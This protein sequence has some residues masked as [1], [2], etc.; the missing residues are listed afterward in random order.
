MQG[1]LVLVTGGAGYIGSHLVRKLLRRGHRVRVLDSLLYGDR[2]LVQFRGNPNFE[3]LVGDVRSSGDLARA[4]KDARAVVAL[5]ALV[6]D[7]A[8]AIDPAATWDINVDA[9][10][11]LLARCGRD[12]VERLVFASSCSVYGANGAE[13]LTEHSHLNPVSLYARTRI[14]SEELLFR[15]RGPVDV[16]VLRLATVC[17]LSERMRFDLMV[18][19]LTANA[20]IHGRIRIFG[21]QQ[22]R[23]HI[24]VQD[25]ADAF[26]RAVEAPRERAANEIFNVG[27]E[28]QN[29]TVGEVADMVVEHIP[30]TTQEQQNGVDDQRSY[31]VGFAHI[32]EKLGFVP[33]RTVDDA[34]SEVHA[35]LRGITDYGDKLY[36]NVKQLL[37]VDRGRASA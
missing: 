22:W 29:F 1:D 15:D 35:V 6:G 32:R 24:H 7:P 26:V 5:A 36:H 33:R 16:V 10:A 9:T 12:R 28:E 13:L 18:N 4:V 23:P 25:A 20:S 30:G 11:E 19:T 17:G 14:A 31:R 37:G 2:G 8:C 21:A 3:L 27:T 34:I